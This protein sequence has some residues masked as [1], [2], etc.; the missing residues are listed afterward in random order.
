MASTSDLIDQLQSILQIEP[1]GEQQ[2]NTYRSM[3][4]ILKRFEPQVAAY[5]IGVKDRERLL[6]HL[7]GQAWFAESRNQSILIGVIEGMH[8]IGKSE[9]EDSFKLTV[10]FP[11]HGGI[12]LKIKYKRQ[13]DRLQCAIYLQPSTEDCSAYLVHFD[14]NPTTINSGTTSL[15]QLD[16]FRRFCPSALRKLTELE[17]IQLMATICDF[18]DRDRH[19]YPRLLDPANPPIMAMALD[20]TTSFNLERFLTIRPT[21]SRASGLPS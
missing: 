20:L 3:H 19:Y 18:Y 1:W 10:N 21:S 14:S 2:W 5:R 7:K 12:F 11:R 15:P 8:V 6:E 9:T 4:A 13:E 16:D 17:Q